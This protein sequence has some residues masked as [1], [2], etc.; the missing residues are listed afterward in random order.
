[1]SDFAELASVEEIKARMPVTY[2]LHR[3]GYRP[4]HTSGR[5]IMY[6]TP[7]RQDTN[8]SLACYPDRDGDI[9]DRWR[10]MARSEGG[11]ALDL[12]GMLDSDCQSFSD[13][14][15]A[16][17]KLYLQF[18]NETDWQSPQPERSTGSFDVEA[19]RAELADWAL[20]N[21]DTVFEDWARTRD[22]AVSHIPARWLAD[23]FNLVWSG[24]EIKAPYLDR[25]GDLVAYKYRKPGEKFKSAAG[26]RG[27]WNIYYGEWLD[28]DESRPVV[29]CEGEPD[30]W[31]GTHA[32][33][34]HVFLGLPSGAGTQPAKMQ[35]RL[36][37]RRV[38]IAFDGDE[39][40]RDASV[41]W[42]KEL[43]LTNTIEIVPMPEGKDLS[44]VADIPGLLTQSRPYEPAMPGL[45]VLN[46]RYHRTTRDG[47]PGAQL[48]DFAL[49]P[50]RVMQS[51]DGALSYEVTDGRKDHLILSEDLVSKNRL[52]SW[53]QQRGLTWAG[54]DTDVALVASRL[55]ADSIFC[56]SEG[57]SDVAGLHNGHIVWAD[58]SIGDSK[59]RYIPFGNKVNL[60]IRV[61]EGVGNP[62]LIYAMR[63]MNDHS[64]TDPILAWAAVAPF[65][66]L[67]DRFP[68]LNVAGTSGSGKTTTV[69][70]II[71]VLT[72]S[73]I[74]KT[75]SSS[76]PWAVEA[77][78]GS[79]NA[80]PVVFDEYRP[81]ARS[82]TLERLEQLARDAYN[83][84]QSSKSSGGDTWNVG[85][86]IRTDAPIAIVGEQSITETS[87][88]ERMV[89]VRILRPKRRDPQQQR[90]LEFINS[91]DNG[92]LAHDYLTFAVKT[93]QEKQ[94]IAVR[95][96]G[97]EDLPERVRFNLGVLD[98]GWRLLNDFL[99]LKGRA[100]LSN[101]DWSGVID[102]TE[103]ITSTNPTIEA[104]SWALG[105]DYASRNVWIDGDEL[106]VS[107]AGFVAD[108]KRSDVFV[109]PG[110]N[111]RTISDQLKADYGAESTRRTPPGVGN[112]KKVWVMPVNQVFPDG[113]N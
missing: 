100:P 33:Q 110:N 40:G 24:T 80:F 90:A 21:D 44:S 62:Q 89:L 23:T 47:A 71:P 79:T 34:D 49:N 92:T 107:V 1:M 45:M 88:A 11:D 82:Q 73:H 6:L 35:S 51:P 112:R 111:A 32:S 95:L 31:S 84:Y 18:L 93:V 63:A 27:L 55:K 37:R 28:T 67:L 83:G 96:S 52:R 101:P 10:D 70:A 43:A 103:D 58:G 3:A 9:V 81:G 78:I 22:D 42:A 57:S 113:V 5:D 105:D 94:N 17:R 104:L 98:A 59:V 69:Q 77:F 19:A 48:A 7:W 41:R 15:D 39:A 50:Q 53:A 25:N 14:L 109:L 72:G 26:T 102:V 74:F 56:P 65:R 86:D 99:A 97:P 54:S 46:N 66:S 91:A 108:V 8:P 29:L 38:L 30:V 106:V 76:T 61:S 87:H 20:S 4:E 68:V 12:I 64:I 36:A 2:V 13:Q 85:Q 75:L 16:A 60:D